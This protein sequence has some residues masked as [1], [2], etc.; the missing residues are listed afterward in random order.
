MVTGGRA[1]QVVST[2]HNTL[3]LY[4]RIVPL[5]PYNLINQ[6]HPDRFNKSYITS[7]EQRVPPLGTPG[8]L[9]VRNP[10]LRPKHVSDYFTV[11]HC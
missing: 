10:G 9:C 7:L 8:E 5:N 3:M 1:V 4:Y 6:C 2:Q 11:P